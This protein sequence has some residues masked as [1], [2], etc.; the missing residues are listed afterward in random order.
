[1]SIPFVMAV[2]I[3]F[4]IASEAR[5]SMTPDFLDCHGLRPRNDEKQVI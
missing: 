1:M 4:V 2:S 5:Q 3:P